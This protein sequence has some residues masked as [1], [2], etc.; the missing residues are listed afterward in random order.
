MELTPE[1]KE[2]LKKSLGFSIG[3][4]FLYVPRAFRENLPKDQWPV[5]TL[6]SKNGMEIAKL[7]DE[8]GFAQ[9]SAKEGDNLKIFMRS[10]SMRIQTLEMGIVKVKG[11]PTENGD[12]VEFDAILKM[13][14]IGERIINGATV[15]K[16]IELLPASLQVELQNAINERSV[17]TEEEL[18]GL[19]Y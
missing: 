10:G 5:F 7:E 4:P 17:L 12:L 6:K 18:Q 15:L 19:A 13:M 1:L 16:L 14:H 11:F 2:K 3:A 9:S 8:T